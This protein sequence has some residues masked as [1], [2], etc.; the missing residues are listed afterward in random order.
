MDQKRKENLKTRAKEAL[1]DKKLNNTPSKNNSK[2]TNSVQIFILG[3]LIGMA[4]TLGLLPFFGVLPGIAE[5]IASAVISGLVSVAFNSLN[6][7]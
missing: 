3:G 6:R 7:N 2:G 1:D 4:L 5:G